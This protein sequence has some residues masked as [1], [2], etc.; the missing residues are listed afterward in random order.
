MNPHASTSNKDKKKGK[1][2]VMV[3]HKLLNRKKKRSF[4]DKQV[5]KVLCH[6]KTVIPLIG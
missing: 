1:A 4:K 6:S 3:K 5:M 2:F